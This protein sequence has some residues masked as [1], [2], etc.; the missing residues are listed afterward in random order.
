MAFPV[1]PA[2]ITETRRE[3]Q[4]GFIRRDLSLSALKKKMK[5]IRRCPDQQALSN[6]LEKCLE[7]LSALKI[8]LCRL[9]PQIECLQ[10]VF[11]E[12]YSLL[13]HLGK[14][15]KIDLEHRQQTRAL[16]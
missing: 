1:T 11:P 10:C 12:K 2:G 8:L 3:K 6:T 16:G 5:Q 13:L 4:T 7:L 9:V 15:S 14:K